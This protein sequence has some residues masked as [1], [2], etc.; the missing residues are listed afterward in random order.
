VQSTITGAVPYQG[1]C[2]T[3]LYPDTSFSSLEDAVSDIRMPTGNRETASVTEGAFNLTF[4]QSYASASPNV[5]CG[6][7][8]AAHKMQSAKGRFRGDVNAAVPNGNLTE[9]VPE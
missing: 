4:L 5:H 3:L 1:I 2:S 7:T 6:A 8:I 9:T